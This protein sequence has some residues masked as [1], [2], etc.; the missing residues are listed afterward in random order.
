MSELEPGW[1]QLQAEGEAFAY[2]TL[3][4]TKAVFTH[5]ASK[6]RSR[7]FFIEVRDADAHR[8]IM[9]LPLIITKRFGLTTISAF[10]YDVCEYAAP[11]VASG[12]SLTTAQMDVIWEAICAV[13]PKSDLVDI[14]QIPERVST[15]PN[16]LAL[17]PHKR[18]SDLSAYGLSL[19]GDPKTLLPRLLPPARHKELQKKL[20]RLHARGNVQFVEAK[21]EMQASQIFEAMLDQRLRRFKKLG[22]F[23]LLS[24]PEIVSFYREA[25]YQSLRDSGPVRLFGLFVD[26]ECIAANYVLVHARTAHGVILS[27]A[28]GKWK[29]CSAGIVIATKIIEW[30]A[31]QGYDYFDLTIGNLAYKSDVGAQSRPLHRITQARTLLGVVALGFIESMI[32][33]KKWMRQHPHYYR[34]LQTGMRWLRRLAYWSGPDKHPQA[35]GSNALHA[36]RDDRE[37]PKTKTKSEKEIIEA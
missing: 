10:N 17:M 14:R 34:A 12:L 2:Q 21:N 30:A 18:D 1:M 6:S 19:E 22:R 11:L 3:D 28:D 36:D 16:P 15:V 4:W 37:A 13:L 7:P 31:E 5:L 35:S 27:I 20:R 29:N 23:D 8:I 25:A 32:E 33:S 24:R 26:D 9:M